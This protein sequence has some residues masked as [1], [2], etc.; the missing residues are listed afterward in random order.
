[1][2]TPIRRTTRP[3]A[4]FATLTILGGCV[5]HEPATVPAATVPIVVPSASPT[6]VVIPSA[7]TTHRVAYPDGAYELHGNGTARNPYY[8]VWVP[9]DV[10]APML[11]SPPPLPPAR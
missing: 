4:V 9:R 11:P 7:S 2:T 5:Y 1:M 8:W 3:A 6:T 10:Q